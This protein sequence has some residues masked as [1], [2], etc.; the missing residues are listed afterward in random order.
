MAQKI[1]DMMS[2]N[3]VALDANSSVREAARAMRDNDIGCVVVEQD[4]KVC[5]IVTD[6]DLVVRGLAEDGTDRD[7]GAF[8]TSELA[9][10]GPDADVGEVIQ[11]MEEKAIRRIP[12][13]DQGRTVGIV[14][15]GDLAQARDPNSALA[16]ISAAPP[17]N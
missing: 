10:V 4:H 5:G 1:S 3:V 16:Q 8:C 2:K 13:V 12:I 9:T 11:L 7:L 17:N 15:I 6:R 14:T